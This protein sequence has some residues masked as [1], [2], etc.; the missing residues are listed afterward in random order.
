MSL[1]DLFEEEIKE[2]EEKIV[3]LMDFASRNISLSKIVAKKLRK[4]QKK[5]IFTEKIMNVLY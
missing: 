2:Q 5:L 1:K 3:N 4:E